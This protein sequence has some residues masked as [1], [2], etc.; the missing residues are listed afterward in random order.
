MSCVSACV[1]VH[2]CVGDCTR[3]LIIL[4]VAAVAPLAWLLALILSSS[5]LFQ[6]PFPWLSPIG[7]C[8][9]TLTYCLSLLLLLLVNKHA[10]AGSKLAS[11]QCR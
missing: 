10:H 5:N 1:C 9:V 8:D 2:A 7:L 11:C 3:G 6:Y 4:E